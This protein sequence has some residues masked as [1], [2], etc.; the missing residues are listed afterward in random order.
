MPEN[1]QALPEGTPVQ[2]IIETAAEVAAVVTETAPPSKEQLI[3]EA[4]VVAA[5]VV[6]EELPPHIARLEKKI[7]E[8][9]ERID[10]VN[11]LL[12][13]LTKVVCAEKKADENKGKLI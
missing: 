13:M 4:V 1:E 12:G 3:A 5:P 6:Q 7:E 9:F 10:M 2:E 11:G 8:I